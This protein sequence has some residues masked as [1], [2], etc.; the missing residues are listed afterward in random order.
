MAIASHA[1]VT[2]D[3]LKA[4]LSIQTASTA[5]DGVLA[6]VANRV[7][8]IIENYLNR[9][10]LAR[11]SGTVA[12]TVTETYTILQ[13]TPELWLAQWPVSSITSVKELSSWPST[14]STVA[15]T[16]GYLPDL[17]RGLLIRV[18][19]SGETAWKTGRNGVQVVYAPGYGSLAAVPYPI[20]DVAVRL[21]ALL[22]TEIDRKQFGVSAY[23]DS[24][25]NVTRFWTA[26]LTEEMQGQLAPY[27]RQYGLSSVYKVQR[28]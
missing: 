10:V 19:G 3:E 8:G 1:L 11:V 24:L 21:G 12:A 28:A 23:S 13:E 22:Y 6:E 9:E 20:R 2:A 26:R 25:G 27:R 4:E 16:T 7:T 5:R 14:Y 15:Q 18:D 17:N